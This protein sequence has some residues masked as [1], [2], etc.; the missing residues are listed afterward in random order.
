MNICIPIPRKFLGLRGRYHMVVRF[1]TTCT[2]SAHHY[3]ICEFDSRSWRGVLDATSCDKICRWLVAG[4]WFS[5]G[6][7]VFSSNETDGNYITEILLTVTLN[8]ITLAYFLP[9]FTFLYKVKV[10]SML[11]KLIN[12]EAKTI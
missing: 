5:T 8:T 12:I 11:Y 6:T 4:R 9:F 3:H 1:T 7:H 10:Y 2:I